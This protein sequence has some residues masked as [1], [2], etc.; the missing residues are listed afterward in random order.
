MDFNVLFAYGHIYLAKEYGGQQEKEISEFARLLKEKN[1]LLFESG[2]LTASMIRKMI[3]SGEITQVET[4]FR[5][6]DIYFIVWAGL[7]EKE[8]VQ[9]MLVLNAGQKAVSNTHQ[10]ELL[11]L[12]FFDEIRKSNKDVQLYREKYHEAGDIKN[13]RR[14]T[15]QFMF[16]SFIV[17]LQSF[18]EQTPLR[19]V[20]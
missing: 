13:G 4:A 11:F 6:F 8:V 20:N 18:V 7:D 14:K 15:G 17:G 16:S 2:V 12:H 9:K 3:S 1:P 10:F 19:I 5:A